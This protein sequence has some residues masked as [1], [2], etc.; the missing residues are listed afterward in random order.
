MIG[1]IGVYR[2]LEVGARLRQLVGLSRELGLVLTDRSV[3]D[4]HRCTEAPEHRQDG[5]DDVKAGG[6]AEELKD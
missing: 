3:L 2:L 4:P 5:Y 6:S 1:F